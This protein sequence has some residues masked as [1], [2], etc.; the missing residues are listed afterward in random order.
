[1]A[2]TMVIDMS[3][4]AWVWGVLVEEGAQ[5]GT[6]YQHRGNLIHLGIH[7]SSFCSTLH[8]NARCHSSLALG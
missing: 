4:H 7:L 6:C 3:R 2:G 5:Q 1:M 8:D